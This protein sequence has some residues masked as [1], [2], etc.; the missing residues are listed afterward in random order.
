MRIVSEA[1]RQV[2]VVA[3]AVTLAATAV[4]QAP[5]ARAVGGGGRPVA[6]TGTRTRLAPVSSGNLRAIANRGRAAGQGAGNRGGVISGLPAADLRGGGAIPI[7]AASRW[8][9]TPGLRGFPAS[10]RRQRYRRSARAA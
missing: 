4:L 8:W 9:G 10:G 7:R 3:G 6:V 2:L 1:G 5:A